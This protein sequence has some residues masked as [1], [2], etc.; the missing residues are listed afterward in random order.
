MAAVPFSII[1]SLI[2]SRDRT[3]GT[4]TMYSHTYSHKNKSS[5]SNGELIADLEIKRDKSHTPSRWLSCKE[6]TCQCRR[7]N[8]HRFNSQVRKIPIQ[9][10]ANH[11]SILAWKIA[12]TE[13]PGTLYSPRGHKESDTTEHTHTYTLLH[14]KWIPSKDLLYSTGNLLNVMQ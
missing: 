7:H 9:E 12:W 3:Q 10:M 4:H 14:L 13:E 1:F 5:I 11:C 8:R 6:S 2:S